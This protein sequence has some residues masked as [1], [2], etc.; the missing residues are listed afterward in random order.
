MKKKVISII[1]VLAMCMTLLFAAGCSSS[2]EVKDNGSGNGASSNVDDDI[3]RDPV[4]LR[5]LYST[6]YEK[7]AEIVRDM[8]TKNGFLVEM[9]PQSDQSSV[10]QVLASGNYD[11]YVCRESNPTKCADYALKCTV[12]TGDVNNYNIGDYELNDMIDA[13]AA[14]GLEEQLETYAELERYFVTERAYMTPLYQE[15]G[16]KTTNALLKTETTHVLAVVYDTDYVDPS[17]RDTRPFNVAATTS[18]PAS[19][20]VLR[21]VSGD[22]GTI[23]SYMYIALCRMDDRNN[24]AIVTD[25]TLSRAIAV[26]EDAQSYYFLLRDDCF[27]TRVNDQAEAVVTDHMVAAEDVVWSVLRA[28]DPN[29]VPGQVAYNY[30]DMIS[31]AEIVTDLDELKSVATSEG[32]SIYDTLSEGAVSSIDRLA[33]TCDDVDNDGGSYQVVRIDTSYPCTSLLNYL[34]QHC[35]GILDSEYVEEM[36]ASVDFAAYDPDKDVL[37]GDTDTLYLGSNYKNTGSYSGA[38]VPLYLD[39]YGVHFVKNEGFQVDE[40]GAK[41]KYLNYLFFADKSSAITAVRSGDADIFGQTASSSFDIIDADEN[42]VLERTK[43]ALIHYMIYNAADESSVCS[44]ETLR[45]A[46][47]ACINPDDVQA[48]I[49]EC[50]SCMSMLASAI[51]TG[52]VFTYTEG[53]AAEY[54]EQYYQELAAK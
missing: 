25:G 38:Y 47:S 16:G 1:L 30:Y 34:T 5:L 10:K 33:A 8:L 27:F 13:A 21:S 51:D 28:A 22:I 6:T 14:V 36:N 24:N 46:I 7:D 50:Y 17:L 18:V 32:V 4:T 53:A 9:N 29:G 11:I 49:G 37:Y 23:G 26:S 15:V 41:I 45:K 43:S 19:F 40:G 42:L 20:D 12:Y 35:G 3:N 48:A 2:L 44:N 39:D 54:L 52:N 31:G